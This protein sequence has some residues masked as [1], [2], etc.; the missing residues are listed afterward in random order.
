MAGPFVLNPAFPPGD[1]RYVCDRC[2]IHHVGH[3]SNAKKLAEH[4]S[5]D[6]RRC[7]DCP[8]SSHSRGQKRP[9]TSAGD[10]GG[11]AGEKRSHNGG[12]GRVQP[13]RK[14]KARSTPRRVPFHCSQ[15]RLVLPATRSYE[16]GWDSSHHLFVW[17]LKTCLRHTSP[18][19]CGGF[20]ATSLLPACHLHTS[21]HCLAF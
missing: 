16:G 13:V 6:D 12:K 18:N 2:G 3:C 15:P 7:I 10:G 1:D 9:A 20:C 8:T 14:R 19:V 5:P 21:E 11:E 17:M 4:E